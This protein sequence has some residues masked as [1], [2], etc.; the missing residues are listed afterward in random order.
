MSRQIKEI[1]Q[2]VEEARGRLEDLLK[3]KER[4]DLDVV[5]TSQLLD[6]IIN[7]YYKVLQDKMH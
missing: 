1:S 6:L 5:N 7:R 2:K 3:I 4:T